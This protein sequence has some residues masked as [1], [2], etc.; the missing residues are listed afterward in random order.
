MPQINTSPQTKKI[1]IDG[2][3][4][5]YMVKNES[6]VHTIFFIHGNSGSASTWIHQLEDDRLH[7][8]RLIAI[9]LPAHGE[10]AS[11]E[12]LRY[13]V[14]DLAAIM[15]KANHEL[16]GN[17]A[18][19]LVGF[20]LGANI[21]CEMLAHSIQPAG[22]ILLGPTIVGDASNLGNIFLPDLDMGIMASQQP[23]EYA[24][25]ELFDAALYN[26]NPDV[27]NRLVNDFI[28]VEPLFRP[29]VFAKAAEGKISNEFELLRQYTKNALVVFGKNENVVKPFYLDNAD[30]PKWRNKVFK[31]D[32]ARHFVHIDQPSEINTL[33]EKY[34][35]EIFT[36]AHA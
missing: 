30:I 34:S 15:V 6:G 14:M 26:K 5:S 18:F 29:T 3:M 13:G 16:I 19:I 36:G 10:S 33:I 17:N 7:N 2:I 4:L 28:M 11:D 25:H 12:S 8:Y 24:I 23:D 35:H 1:E 9:D 22:L 20:S 31:V 27:L 32:N 21:V